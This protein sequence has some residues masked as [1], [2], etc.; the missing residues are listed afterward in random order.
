MQNTAKTWPLWARV[1]V[2]L[3]VGNGLA[4]AAYLRYKNGGAPAVKVVVDQVPELA[5][6]KISFAST[7]SGAKVSEQGVV[8]GVTPFIRTYPRMGPGQA[9]EFMFEL[10]GHSPA[11]VQA[12]LDQERI[13]VHTSLAAAPAVAAMEPAVAQP[14]VEPPVQIAEKAVDRTPPRRIVRR[15]PVREPKTVTKLD[16]QP[17]AVTKLI[18]DDDGG[19]RAVPKL[20]DK[21]SGGVPKL[22]DKQSGVP[23]LDDKQS[24]V[25]KL[26]EDEPAA[27]KLIDEDR[28]V[29]PKLK[30]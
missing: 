23:K 25:P 20:D 24:G 19:R 8:L 18:D 21:K 9:R 13:Y 12:F 29:V 3:L 30:D 6:S 17:S 1:L 10:E 4:Y 7:P 28:S 22:D 16:D 5:E 15:E 27:P 11:K 2:A 14:A 26:S